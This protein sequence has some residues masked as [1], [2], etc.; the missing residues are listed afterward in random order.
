[1]IGLSFSQSGYPKQ[2]VLQ[3]DTVIAITVGQMDKI[4][5]EHLQKKECQET[6]KN[7]MN[8]L[9]YCEQQNESI[10]V[11]AVILESQKEGLR[12]QIEVLNDKHELSEK[13]K[14][15]LQKTIKKQKLSLI[16]HKV[17]IGLAILGIILL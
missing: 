12:D 13:E 14:Q 10:M 4:N 3:N 6:N 9:N 7:L 2:I 1:M 11:E 15:E 8:T 16:L 17:A 5:Q